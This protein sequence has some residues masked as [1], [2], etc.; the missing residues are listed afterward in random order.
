[1]KPWILL[2]YA[3]F[4]ALCIPRSDAQTL[5]W[6]VPVGIP[7]INSN[8]VSWYDE[9][10]A[11]WIDADG[12]GVHDQFV[13]ELGAFALNFDPNES[14]V[15]EWLT[16]WRVFDRL[17]WDPTF[18]FS[19]SSPT[20]LNNVTSGSDFA[21]DS[22]FSF[23]GL[24]AYMWVRFGNE[25]VPGSEWFLARAGE[26]KF[27]LVAGDCCETE[28]IDWSFS[29]LTS[30]DIPKWGVQN[31][32]PGPGVSNFEAPDGFDGIQTH[33]FIPEPSSA[34]LTFIAGFGLLLR[35]RRNA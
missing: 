6:G 3:V 21:S 9:D 5:E 17:I 13:F 22:T 30:G 32:V 12:D 19:T 27:P 34:L 1:M 33:T 10:G 23:A 15:G 4:C 7:L 2:T 26:W 28:F 35:R 14:N 31:N 16:H 24:D 25:P 29:D 20:I 11:A 8:G 18:I